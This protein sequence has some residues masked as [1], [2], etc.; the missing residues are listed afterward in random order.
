[1]PSPTLEK[2]YHHPDSIPTPSNPTMK[3]GPAHSGHSCCG[4]T[5]SSE[6]AFKE[7]F[8]DKHDPKSPNYVMPEDHNAALVAASPTGDGPK[9]FG[10]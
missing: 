6:V 1:M 10:E 8:A 4:K 7:H 5:F 9:P 3:N 2:S